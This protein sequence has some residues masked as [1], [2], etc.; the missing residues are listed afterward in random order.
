MTTKETKENKFDVREMHDYEGGSIDK[1]IECMQ[2][3]DTTE[4]RLKEARE[5]MSFTRARNTIR[6]TGW[7]FTEP[8]APCGGYMTTSEIKESIVSVFGV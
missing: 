2:N 8:F 4:A 7:Y 6:R 5:E 1:A 3:C